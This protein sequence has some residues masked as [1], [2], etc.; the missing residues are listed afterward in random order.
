[1]ALTASGT[2]TSLTPKLMLSG[3]RSQ[4]V[5]AAHVDDLAGYVTGFVRG[6]K[7]DHGGDIGR[8]SRTSEGNFCQLLLADRIRDAAGHLRVDKTRTDR[9]RRD[10]VSGE[11]FCCRP[12]QADDPSCGGRVVRLSDVAHPAGRRD[13]HDPTGSCGT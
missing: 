3:C 4:H 9:I 2:E 13:I 8:L 7:R 10:L 1:M 12:R 6:Q 5:S 11:L